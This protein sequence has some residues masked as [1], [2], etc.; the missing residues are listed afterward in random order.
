M[1]EF[2]P[3][4]PRAAL[5]RIRGERASNVGA[6]PLLGFAGCARDADLSRKG[7]GWRHRAMNTGNP[8][9]AR[10]WLVAPPKIIWRRR[11]CV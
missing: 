5:A 9:F 6:A 11:L 2:G 8:A 10:M 3:L 4:A 7:R 1:T